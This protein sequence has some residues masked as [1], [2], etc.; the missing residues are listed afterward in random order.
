MGVTLDELLE[1]SGINSLKGE[2]TVKTASD[3]ARIG[4]EELVAELRKYA[5]EEPQKAPVIREE[6]ARELAEKTA[7]IFIIKQT[8]QE[9]DKLA[10]LGVDSNSHQK[11]ATFI[12]VAMDKGHSEQ[13]I[14]E[15]LKTAIVGRIG[16]AVKSGVQAMKRPIS[17]TAAKTVGSIDSGEIRLLREKMLK[18]G[19]KEGTKHLQAVESQYGRPVVVKMLSIIQKEGSHLPSWANKYL[20]KD[21]G[22]SFTIKGPGGAEKS[23]SMGALK[24]YGVP[25]AAGGA[26][27][28]VGAKGGKDKKGGRGV[29]IVN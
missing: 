20:P 26:G 29:V 22:K 5:N 15:F 21:A 28:A 12:K 16:R 14:A 7:E 13:E 23:I 6:A 17:R 1:N 11:L 9:I 27:I 2:E 24:R 18:G 4:G 3:D 10:S 8:M 25:A 19:F